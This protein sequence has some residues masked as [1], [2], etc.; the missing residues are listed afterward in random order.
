MEDMSN[1]FI[2][3]RVKD[4]DIITL[5]NIEDDDLLFKVCNLNK[6]SQTLC[7]DNFWTL[8]IQQV[9]PG[10]KL[11]DNYKGS[12]QK[13]YLMIQNIYDYFDKDDERK[14]YEEY[15][16]ND[17]NYNDDNYNDDN[18]NDNNYNDNNYNVQI[19][20]WATE[21]NDVGLLNSMLELYYYPEEIYIN[22]AVERGYTNILSLLI[23]KDAD[24]SP[25]LD[26]IINAF[27]NKYYDT[28]YLL[29][30][31]NIIAIDDIIYDITI[32]KNITG[33]KWL[34]ENFK[35]TQD[36]IDKL[37]IE[38]NDQ[39]RLSKLLLKYKLYPS[40]SAF[41]T[42]KDYNYD[43]YDLLVKINTKNKT[44]NK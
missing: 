33:L 25:D 39:L 32:Y 34:I 11:H 16:Y 40:S 30:I 28:I 31:N 9:L 2:F 1:K 7:D 26:S 17:D 13:L 10:F 5:L 35:L 22:H 3:T 23:D 41:N 14:E 15:D 37:F 44:I 20:N 38:D 4:V 8:K 18:Y 24:I 27:Q 12:G 36:Q 43:L 21:Y 42:I 29:L 6:Y 19:S